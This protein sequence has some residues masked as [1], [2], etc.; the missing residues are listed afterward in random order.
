MKV[1]HGMLGIENKLWAMNARFAFQEH[2]VASIMQSMAESLTL[3]WA[4]EEAVNKLR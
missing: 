4:A 2:Y 3:K 1:M